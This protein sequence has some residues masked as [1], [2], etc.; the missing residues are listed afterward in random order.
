MASTTKWCQTDCRNISKSLYKSV[1]DLENLIN[2]A[3]NMLLYGCGDT[4]EKAILDHDRH[5]VVIEVSN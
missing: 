1:G 3:D 4:I 5:L 2:I